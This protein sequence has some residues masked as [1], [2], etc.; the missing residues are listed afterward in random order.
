M[1]RDGVRLPEGWAPQ[2]DSLRDRVV[3]ITGATGGLGRAAAHACAAAGATVVLVGRRTRQLE[4][5]YDALTAEGAAQPAICPLNLESATPAQYDE[6]AQTI[7]RELGHLDG[8]LHAAAYFDGLTPLDQHAPDEWLRTLQVNLSAPFALTQ[9]VLPLMRD[10]TDAAVVFVLDDPGRMRRA[11][12][13]AYGVGKAGLEAL[14][15]I[16]H[17]ETCE[18][19]VRTHALLPAPMRTL[20]R[21]KAWFGEDAREQPTP[22]VAAQAVV[23]LMSA[24]GAEARGRMLDLR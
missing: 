16:L 23:Y 6:L 20:L 24:A 2:G 3:M 22:E 8:V 10:S 18:G 21:R 13:G 14:V 19:P 5:V 1:G 15:S 7:E 9:A 4:A 17:E 12:W 11:H